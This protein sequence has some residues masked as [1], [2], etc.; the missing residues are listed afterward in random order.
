MVGECLLNSEMGVDSL[1]TF[2]AEDKC[3]II[4]SNSK[5]KA[6]VA[7]IHLRLSFYDTSR[8]SKQSKLTRANDII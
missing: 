7:F 8:D 4:R 3:H 1:L 6:L 2:P 5:K